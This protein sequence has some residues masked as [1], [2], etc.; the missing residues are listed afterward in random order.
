M[1]DYKTHRFTSLSDYTVSVDFDCRLY[2]YDIAGSIAHVQMLTRQAIISE[3]NGAQ[4]TT[5]LE[6]IRDEIDAGTF[7][8]KRQL[9]D[10]HMNIESRL[11]ELIGDT[12]GHLQTARSRND[13][14]ATTLRLFV[15]DSIDRT[16]TELHT[17]Q[18]VL[19]ELADA[20]KTLVLPGYTH[21]QRAQ[22]VL[23]SHH[24]LAYFE[25]FDRDTERLT[26]CHRRTNIL[27]LG[28]GALAGVP[29][30]IDRA[31]VAQQL[32]F[33]DISRNS[34][35]AVSDR[36]FV[37]EYVAAIATCMM[38]CSRLAEE[39]I[40]WSSTEFAFI[41]LSD[42][43]I[44]GSSMMPQKRNPDFAELARGKTGRVYGDLVTILTMLKG[45]PLTYNRD[46]QEDKEALF[47]AT[48]TLIS[49][50]QAFHGMLNTV[51][52]NKDRMEV[53]ASD[54]SILA[55]DLADFLVG[56]GVPF[57]EAH[58]VVSKLSD[59]A[60]HKSSELKGLSI[61][62]YQRF[63]PAFDK[64]VLDLSA[65]HSTVARDVIGGTAPRR[66]VKALLE[67]RESWEK[68]KGT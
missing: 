52:V 55:T 7:V 8:W 57:R 22:P 51:T 23:L 62:E 20:H 31:W 21:L 6:R 43:W 25:M 45:L 2:S 38:H 48:D 26:D 65:E 17:L 1:P 11:H 12:A 68:K 40:L 61:E 18:G 59:Y 41:Q 24:L 46:L 13:Q 16:K 56:K 53:A 66:V 63:S 50:L 60:T 9:E 64:E 5:G 37:V 29:Y 35:D 39:L 3:E 10:V 34:M 32:G 58:K 19:L 28:S 33:A 47:D 54:D 67:A 14:V 27:P 36:D 4:L 44:T 15:K 42:E 30:Q 49:T